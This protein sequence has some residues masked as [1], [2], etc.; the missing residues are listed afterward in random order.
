MTLSANLDPA[1]FRYD[2]KVDLV[3]PRLKTL[4][5][6]VL[7]SKI[8][9]PDKT[10]SGLLFIPECAMSRSYEEAGIYFGRVLVAGPD[11]KELKVGD[12][13]MFARSTYVLWKYKDK[14]YRGLHEADAL[15]ICK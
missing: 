9:P 14:E 11:C 1:Y 15:A 10:E 3:L 8:D 5:D 12:K 7:V 4:G 13:I 2:I 6:I